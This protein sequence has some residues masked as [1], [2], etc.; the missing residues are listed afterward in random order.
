MVCTAQNTAKSKAA[1][2]SSQNRLI[3]LAIHSTIPTPVPTSRTQA[4]QA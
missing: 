3:T 1:K 2:I 4:S